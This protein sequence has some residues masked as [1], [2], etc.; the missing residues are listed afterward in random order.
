MRLICLLIITF[1]ISVILL[2]SPTKLYAQA[3]Q[4]QNIQWKVYT[5]KG[6]GFSIEYPSFM[7]VEEIKSE[8]PD[9]I[10]NG[11]SNTLAIKSPNDN[12]NIKFVGSII[13]KTNTDLKF[14]I[15]TLSD[16]FPISNKFTLGSSIETTK[17]T[18]DGEKT[19]SVVTQDSSQSPTLV[20]EIV[21]VAH[22]GKTYGLYYYNPEEKE[23]EN[24]LI[25]SHM[26]NSIKWLN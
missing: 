11:S 1:T 13:S 8:N 3:D 26:F 12:D 6:L 15:I 9:G 7:K 19:A 20:I 10:G 23:N 16:I 25:R 14:T 2:N 17:Y 21:A 24:S 4:G 5:S 18:I 22:N